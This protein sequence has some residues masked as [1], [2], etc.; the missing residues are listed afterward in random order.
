MSRHESA[1][2]RDV[3]VA[4]VVAFYPPALGGVEVVVEELSS[5]LARK[6]VPVRVLTSTAHADLP[7][8]RAERGGVEVHRH[9]AVEVAHTPVMFGLLWTLLRLPRRT[10]LHVHVAHAFVGEAV[11]LVASLR[12]MPYLVHFH[13]NIDASG[14]AGFLL[15]YYKRWLMGPTLRRAAGVIALTPGMADDLSESFGVDRDRIHVVGNAASAEFIEAGERRSVERLDRPLRVLFAGRLAAQKNLGR[16][17]DA[18]ELL[19]VPVELQLAGDGEQRAMLEARAAGVHRH[20]VTFLGRIGHAEL[21]ERLGW[22]DV[23]V[24][25]S[26]REGMPLVMLEAMAMGV[27]VLSTDVPGSRELVDGRGLLV[28]PTPAAVAEGLRTLAADHELRARLSR[29]GV[30]HMRTQ[31]WDHIADRVLEVYS[32]AGLLPSP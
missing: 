22:A 13:L 17:F 9:R 6:Q 29:Q 7:A 11:R 2:A 24:M 31:T 14:P 10:V 8:G 25:T 27:P 21:I 30:D 16:L 5:A 32:A 28:E 12:R 4:Q 3:R 15:P 20:D 19:E 18:L 26:D 23:F 1:Q